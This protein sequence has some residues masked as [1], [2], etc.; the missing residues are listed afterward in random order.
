[1][2]RLILIILFVAFVVP[3][4]FAQNKQLIQ[5]VDPMIGTDGHAHTF[6]GATLP[7]GMVQLSPSNDFKAWD[8]CSG[9]HYSDSILKGFAHTHISGAGLAGLGDILL[10]PT[11]GETKIIAGTEEDPESGFRSRFSHKKEEASPGYYAVVLDDYNVKVELTCSPRVGYHKYTFNTAGQANVILDPTHNIME[12]VQGTEIEFVSDSEVRGWKHCNGEGGDRKVYFYARFSKSFQKNGVAIDD[13]IKESA[14]KATDRKV[15][16]FVSFDV[17]KGEEVLV[18]VALSFVSYEGAKA[19]FDAEAQGVSFDHVLESAQDIWEEKMNKF[20]I[21]TD[22]LSDKRNFY[23]AVYHSMISPNLISDVSGEYIVE[24]EKYH[25]TFDQYSNF[26]TW[27]T[28]RAVHPLLS[29]VEHDKTADFINSLSS[30][31]TDAKVGLPVWECLGHDNVCMIGY[32][33]VSVM[34]DAIMKDISGIDQQTAYD[35]MYAAAFNLEKHSNSYDVNGMN[36]YIDM[37]FVPAEIGSSVSKTTEYNYYD[38]CLSQVARKMKKLDDLHLFQQ[39]SKGYRNLFDQHTGYLLPKLQNGKFVHVD[40]TKW[41]GLVHNYVSGNIWG[42]SSYVPHD[43]G[44]L[45]QLHG[46]K[47][48]FAYWLDAIFADNSKIG[49]SQHVDISGFIGKYGHGDE[50]SHQ[51]PYLYVHA[52][53]AW[54]SQKLVREILSRFYHD[55]PAGL[56]NNDDLG[57]MSSWY[58]FGSLGFYPVCPGS[59]QYQIGS[60]AYQKASINL[61]NGKVFSVVANHNSE[62][63]VYIQS[64]R[65]NG[66]EFN[67]AFITY[68]QIKNGGEL[69]FEM[70]SKPNLSWG[71]ESSD[72]NEM[73]GMKV[74]QAYKLHEEK[75]VLMPYT[76]D[77]AFSFEKSK[78]I[79]LRCGTNGAE[80]RYTTDG[81]EPDLSSKKYQ[82]PIHVRDDVR[83]KA[84]AFKEGLKA[85]GVLNLQYF[86]GLPFNPHTGY[87][88][89]SVEGDKIGYG[90]QTGIQ[91]IDGG[92]GST[93]F[94]DGF[95][96]GIDLHDMDV[97]I[98]LGES[99]EISEVKAGILIY[100]G[101]WIFNP[102]EVEI[103]VSNDQKNY[104]LVKTR[105]LEPVK[106]ES[107][108]VIRPSIKFPKVSCRYLKVTFKNGPIPDWHM[109]GGRKHWI[110]VD[111]IL[112]N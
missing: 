10:M 9:Y 89:I 43:M 62:K 108:Y 77:T 98:D 28:Y 41:D 72:L 23:T 92:F 3:K 1:M 14:K 16:G 40:K 63:N 95:W 15:K 33:T 8:W 42:Y 19:N 86:K 79:Q 75:Q 103:Y 13:V 34:S 21:E 18:K 99:K 112:I 55:H 25:S 69:V 107:R 96:T 59:N 6:P 109:A 91:L 106:D 56:D 102:D 101:A 111:E 84:I 54:K 105:S 61:E 22:K 70:G 7:F 24:G 66:K 11:L 32:S 31:F 68:D 76:N 85:S 5:F 30:R 67:K 45:I 2:K 50:P 48:K 80:I 110:F 27:D 100:P 74:S 51:M 17:E 60:P 73:Q 81:S 71:T 78:T 4:L 26:S 36:Y 65:L 97:D 38:W 87:P 88:K 52:G 20:Q 47:E 57:Q 93:T 53:Q 44:Y 58:V 64:A 37:D 39:R 29:I 46:G 104:R 49:G 83:L 90:K 94:N 35:A 12:N 82:R